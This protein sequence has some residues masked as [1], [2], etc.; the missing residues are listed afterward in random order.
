MPSSPVIGTPTKTHFEHGLVVLRVGQVLG[1][2]RARARRRSAA[3]R[4]C[5][6]RRRSGPARGRRGPGTAARAGCRGARRRRRSGRA[7]P[8]RP[9]RASPIATSSST[10]AASSIVHAQTSLGVGVRVERLA[11]DLAADHREAR[12]DRASRRRRRSRSPR[13][14]TRGPSGVARASRAAESSTDLIAPPTSTLGRAQRGHRRA[15]P[16]RARRASGARARPR[17]CPRSR[18]R[19]APPAPRRGPARPSPNSRCSCTP[20]FMSS[21]W[22]CA[23]VAAPR[24]T[25]SVTDIG[26]RQTMCPMSSVRPERRRVARGAPAAARSRPASR[27]ASRARA[28]TPA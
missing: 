7:R 20:R 11:A 27:P 24:R 15:G 13:A 16:S 9:R 8:A 28:R 12:A 17:P 19:S 18:P 3:C 10:R 23:S 1:G 6:S 21:M 22:T 5:G 26:S 14:A 2:V 4:W 25:H